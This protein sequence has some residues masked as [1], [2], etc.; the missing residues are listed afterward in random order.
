M[1]TLL[2][3][4]LVLG[5]A[6][7]GLA[8]EP[9]SPRAE[10]RDW[11]ECR[12]R[13]NEAASR[14]EYE[15]FHD[16]AWRA[17][18]KGPAKD[19]ALMYLLAR[20]QS[21]SGRPTDALVMIDRLTGMH[22][23]T[24]ATT[25]EDLSRMRALPQWPALAE[26]IAA[27]R[28]GRG[29]EPARTAGPGSGQPGASPATPTDT[30]PS[31]AATASPPAA[32]AA[33]P[34]TDPGD[35]ARF[36]IA[37]PRPA[38]LVYDAVSRRFVI[39]SREARRLSVVDEFSQ[40]VA[41]LSGAQ[42]GFDDIAA[43]EIDPLVG[44][45]WVVSSP[46]EQGSP[47][48]HKLQLVSG[49]V[50]STFQPAAH[51]GPARFVDVAVAG[52]STVLVLDEPGKRILRLRPGG[53]ALETAARLADSDAVSLA[54]AGEGIV[55]VAGERGIAR[56]ELGTDATTSIKAASGVDLSRLSR[57]RYYRGEL[58]G[59]QQ[60]GDSYRA[61]RISL[62]RSGSR[63]TKVEALDAPLTSDAPGAAA[64]VGDVFYYLARTAGSD[65]TIRRVKLK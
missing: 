16:L 60:A 36:T 42:A 43:L 35:A 48:L 1:W 34:P 23:A 49:R 26:R 7:L 21:V 3:S 22:V 61:V 52:R 58:V 53:A 37:E 33:S 27:L 51:P 4:T 29:P 31:R 39:A 10:C 62:D 38:G 28:A 5:G 47:T 32:A 2:I 59:L 55:Y 18:Q 41:T 13:A 50:L 65:I 9:S 40:H 14:H 20:A 56:V 45:L 19:P 6:S 57:I 63:A 46:R 15:A 24:D 44:S 30:P 12:D 17:V 54:P 11:Q 25:D 64:I 8:Q